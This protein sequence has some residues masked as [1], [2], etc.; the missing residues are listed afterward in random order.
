MVLA[1]MSTVRL[2][3]NA[4]D[5]DE[6][7]LVWEDLLLKRQHTGPYGNALIVAVIRLKTHAY[8]RPCIPWIYCFL[9]VELTEITLVVE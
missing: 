6:G 7:H 5:N 4:A 3:E 2:S 9:G 1:A 8:S